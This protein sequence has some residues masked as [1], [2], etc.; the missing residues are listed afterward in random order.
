MSSMII[1]FDIH[2]DTLYS[3][4]SV[5]TLGEVTLGSAGFLDVLEVQL[6]LPSSRMSDTQSLVSYRQCLEQA[7]SVGRFYSNSFEVDPIGVTQ[8]LLDWRNTCYLHGWSGEFSGEVPRRLSDLAE[9]EKLAGSEVECEGQRLQRIFDTLEDRQTQIERIVLLM[10]PDDLPLMWRRVLN[11]F[12]VSIHDG[13]ALSPGSRDGTDLSVVQET[14]LGLQRPEDTGKPEKRT[15]TGDGSLVLVQGVSRDISARAVAEYLNQLDADSGALVIAER[16]GVVIDNALASSGAPRCGFR[17]YSRFRAVT[18]VLK[19]S[20]GLVWEPVESRL[21][22]QFLLHPVGPLNRFVRHTLAGAVADQPGIGGQRWQAAIHRIERKIHETGSAEEVARIKEG[23]R[24]WLQG[25][26]YSVHSGAPIE[27]LIERSQTCAEWLLKRLNTVEDAGE[28]NTYG[29]A[30]TQAKNLLD[31]LGAW[32]GEG[33]TVISKVELDRLLD[34]V[35]HPL[36]DPESYS[37]AGHVFACENPASVI[38][39]ADHVVWWDM[40][41]GSSIR[42]YPWSSTELEALADND[43]ELPSMEMLHR[44]RTRDWL[45][46]VMNA[47]RQLVLIFHASEKGIHPLLTQIQSLFEGY[48]EI[49]LDEHLLRGDTAGQGATLS[50]PTL[51]LDVKPLPAKKTLVAAARGNAG[52]PARNRI[53]LQFGEAAESPAHLAS[54]IRCAT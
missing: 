53:V 8:T 21:L 27:G 12:E 24:F 11:A 29:A 4:P 41:P 48:R 33:R 30:Y 25:A 51:A 17:H 28:R 10:D 37:E 26:R 6:G 14:L 35:T 3:Q 13:V 36:A 2:L 43:I 23:I 5:T 34:E 38:N 7:N 31:A 15:L 50:I 40:K 18:Q 1:H 47:R 54:S 39:P 52:R 22:L 20:L 42:N 45:H 46:P 9:I 16:D 19:L 49:R 32:V 44:R